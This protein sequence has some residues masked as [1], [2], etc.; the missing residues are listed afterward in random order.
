MVKVRITALS[1]VRELV[2][3]STKEVDFNGE[4]VKD[5]FASVYTSKGVCLN[6]VLTEGESLK[7]GYF[8]ILNGRRL[9][10]HALLQK[11]LKDGDHL[12]A[13]ELLRIVGG[14]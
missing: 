9:D 6:E 1:E 7:P 8:L 12:A 2:G 11:E 3:W 4:T 5:L 13:M 10:Y 14:G